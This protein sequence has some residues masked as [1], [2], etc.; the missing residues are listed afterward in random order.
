LLGSIQRQQ[1]AAQK[2][3]AV[4]V[5]LERAQDSILG[6]RQLG[7]D[8]GSECDLRPHYGS[9]DLTSSLTRRPSARPPAFDITAAITLPISFWEAAPV[10]LRASA[11][12]ASSSSSEISAGRY[13]SMMLASRSSD[14][15][16]SP[17]PPLR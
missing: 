11:T 2:N 4:E 14:V 9:L 17:R 16:A 12:S 13:A 8:G 6:A 3:L 7:R 5:A 10:S 15:A 1:V